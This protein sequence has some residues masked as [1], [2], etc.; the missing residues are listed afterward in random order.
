MEPR[1]TELRAGG[2]DLRH[3]EFV[4]GLPEEIPD[5]SG[6]EHQ[7]RLKMNFFPWMEQRMS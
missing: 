1:L 6:V 4:L 5:V 3:S 2:E 7:D